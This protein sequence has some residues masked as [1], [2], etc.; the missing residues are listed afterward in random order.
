MGWR[1]GDGRRGENEN[2]DED[3]DEEEE[4]EGEGGFGG[5]EV[6]QCYNPHRTE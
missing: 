1:G 4:E 2:E 5:L 6:L 3:E